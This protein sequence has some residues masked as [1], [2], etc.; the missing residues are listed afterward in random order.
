MREQASRGRQGDA[1]R[2]CAVIAL[3]DER[4]TSVARVQTRDE[5]RCEVLRFTEWLGFEK[6]NATAVAD[7]SGGAS[8]FAWAN[9]T[10]PAFESLACDF[11]RAR[12]D[13]VAKHCK[14]RGTPIVWDQAT[15][16][17]VGLGGHWEEQAS[18]GYRTGIAVALHLPGGK[19][20]F[21]GIDR[22][23]RLPT[24]RAEIGWMVGALQIFVSYAQEAA[25]QLLTPRALRTGDVLALS[26]R[27]LE[28]L[29]WTMEGKTA[30]EVGRI[31][32]ISEQTAVKHLNNAT[33][34]LEC[35][36]KH[37]A[38]VKAMRLGLIQ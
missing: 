38:V 4:F 28:C 23:Q 7:I 37:H 32:S 1:T 24:Q 15:Y 20:F 3:L 27:E 11:D 9:N 2:S 21:I 18:H 5:F 12:V 13:P 30:W 31:L 34:K 29:R 6:M 22:E 17:A 35:A 26:P 19:H 8:E 33:H 25:A 14:E 10:P 16:T 36:N